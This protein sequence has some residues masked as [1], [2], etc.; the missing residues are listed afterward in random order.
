MGLRRKH[1]QTLLAIFRRPV[2][3]TI[4]W[5]DVEALLKAFGAD[6]EERAGS[7]VAVVFPGHMP[8][9]FHRP[10]PRP[11][12]DKGAVARLRDWLDGMGIS[13]DAHSDPDTH[14]EEPDQ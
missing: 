10:H 14:S 11:E 13:P 4:L 12:T 8:A 3:G 7:R 9:V 6:V 5:S 1:R 2:S